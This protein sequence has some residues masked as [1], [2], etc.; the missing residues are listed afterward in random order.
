MTTTMWHHQ[1]VVEIW[2]SSLEA[3]VAVGLSVCQ[4]LPTMLSHWHWYTG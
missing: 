3:D 2:Q 4:T 1:I